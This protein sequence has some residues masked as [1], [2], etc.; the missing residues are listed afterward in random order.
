[1]HLTLAQRVRWFA[2][3]YK[4]VFK[5]YHTALIK[6]LR[7]LVSHDAIIFD[8]GAH[9]GQFCKQFAKLV[10]QGKVYAFEPGEYAGSLLKVML[11]SHR[12]RN[13][14]LITKGLSDAEGKQTLYLPVKRSGAFG[15]G[16][17]SLL[18]NTEYAEE[19]LR[20]QIIALTT[21]DSVVNER[22]LE[23]LDLLKV[24][25]EGW[26][27]PVLRG[28][29]QSIQ[30]FRPV[31]IVEIVERFLARTGARADDFFRLFDALDYTV[32]KTSEHNGYHLEP[33]NAF[34]GDCDYV[35][36]PRERNIV[37]V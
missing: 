13:V 3:L 32:Y 16:L 6:N 23:R 30:R 19:K 25:I 8:V 26:E 2:H 27:L 22:G 5:N 31:V 12:L 4:A 28:A 34:S 11:S 24:D 29:K 21:I 17:A 15:F 14:E 10:P 36:V 37:Q 35:F 18:P 9:S 1:M 33:V 7:K 20:T